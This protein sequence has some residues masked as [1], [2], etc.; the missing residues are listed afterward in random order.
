MLDNLM[1]GHCRLCYCSP[2]LPVLLL[3]AFVVLSR[4]PRISGTAT[5][6][7][8]VNAATM[9]LVDESLSLNIPISNTR[10]FPRSRIAFSLFEPRCATFGSRAAAFKGA[11]E[12]R[13]VSMAL[14]SA[15]VRGRT[16][17]LRQMASLVLR[18]TKLR[19]NCTS[20]SWCNSERRTTC[21][22]HHGWPV[23]TI[24]AYSSLESG[25]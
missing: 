18:T 20:R 13:S 2:L 6:A 23:G 15:T 14:I 10:L 8:A 25:S 11:S 16:W 3:L 21:R 1:F 9:L 22:F 17:L 19:G 12:R 24:K 7:S 4:L 5:L